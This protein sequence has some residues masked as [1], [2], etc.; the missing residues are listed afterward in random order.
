MCSCDHRRQA[1][2]EIVFG[3]VPQQRIEDTVHG[4]ILS[5]LIDAAHAG[6]RGELVVPPLIRSIASAACCSRHS[7]GLA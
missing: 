7:D 1:V 2:A 5:Q 4:E 3:E 6:V